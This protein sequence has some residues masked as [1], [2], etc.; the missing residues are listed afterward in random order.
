M[1]GQSA[2]DL[3]TSSNRGYEPGRPFAVRALWLVVEALVLLNPVVTSYRLKQAVLRAFGARIGASPVLKPGIHV[4]YP[5]RLTLGDNVW[6]GERC[7]IDN[8]A[9]VE[10]GSNVCVSQGAYLCTGNHDWS[11]PGMGLV[12]QPITIADGAWVGAFARVAPGVRV[13][14]DSVVTLGSTLLADTE[15]DG[16]YSGHP[17]EWVRRRTVGDRAESEGQ[18]GR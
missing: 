7:W 13:A 10:I 4:K 11:D 17:A 9:D 6:L 3:S 14:R 16:I 15:P 5:W 18:V 1:A 12:T 2:V 8:M